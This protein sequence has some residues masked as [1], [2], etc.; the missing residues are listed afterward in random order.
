MSLSHIQL[1]FA[2]AERAPEVEKSFQ[3]KRDVGGES[4]ADALKW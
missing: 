4:V 2:Q 1:T 3:E